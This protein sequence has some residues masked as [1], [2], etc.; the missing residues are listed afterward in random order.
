M[1]SHLHFHLQND[2]SSPYPPVIFLFTSTW[3]FSNFSNHSHSH[4]L[5]ILYLCHF[6]ILY[7]CVG[8]WGVVIIVIDLDFFDFSVLIVMVCWFWL[9]LKLYVVWSFGVQ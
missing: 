9:L 4:R 1:T 6:S 3:N 2:K 5:G 8:I 7:F